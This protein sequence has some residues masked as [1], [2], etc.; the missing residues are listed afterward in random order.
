[1]HAL[2]RQSAPLRFSRQRQSSVKAPQGTEG[3]SL[4]ARRFIEIRSDP[5]AS[6]KYVKGLGKPTHPR[7]LAN[8]A[9]LPPGRHKVT[10]S[11][12]DPNHNVCAGQV[13]TLNFTIPEYK[14]SHTH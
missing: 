2:L 5:W 7:D 13:V 4:I 8:I 14:K 11:L 10:I 12:V 3:P 1:M 9:G 6:P